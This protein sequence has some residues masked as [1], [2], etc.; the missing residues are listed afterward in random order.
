MATRVLAGLRVSFD[1]AS[2]L[3]TCLLPS[4][5]LFFLGSCFHL[6]LSFTV[7][8]WVP[9][10]RY[11]AD[12][13]S[14]KKKV[15]T[16]RTNA[17]SGTA[18][19]ISAT[20]PPHLP[21]LSRTQSAATALDGTGALQLDTDGRARST[22]DLPGAPLGPS[23]TSTST[24]FSTIGSKST[25]V[26]HEGGKQNKRVSMSLGALPM[27]HLPGWATPGWSTPGTEEGTPFSEWGGGVSGE[28]KRRRRRREKKKRQ[29]VYVGA[30]CVGLGRCV[31][32]YSLGVDY[33][34]RC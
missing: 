29:E 23:L 2:S 10:C 14:Q 1:C 26:G 4:S 25:I 5:S 8:D 13:I 12:D 21:M 17:S 31:L 15:K 3:V 6:F 7:A 34:A 28:E 30:V 24:K 18:S 19:P 11:S 33:D 16:P 27:P 9:L 22:S 32:I 20:T